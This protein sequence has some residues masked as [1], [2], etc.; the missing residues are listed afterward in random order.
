MK[1]QTIHLQN[2]ILSIFILLACF[3]IGCTPSS[4]NDSNSKKTSN[5]SKPFFQLLDAATTG[6]NFTNEVID[7]QDFNILTYRNYYNG[8]GVAIGDINNDGLSDIFFTANLTSNKLYLNKG[9]FVFEEI[10]EQAG[11]GGNKPWSTGVTMA[12]VNGDGWLDIYVSNSGDLADN[13]KENELFINNKNNTFTESATEYGLDNKGYSTQAAFFDYDADGDL[14]CYLLNNSFKDP[15]KIELYRSMR[16]IPDELGGDKLYRNDAIPP[17]GGKKGGF[18]D[19]SKEAG[20]YSS[21]IGFGLGTCIG[22]INQDMLPDIYV[23]N[24]FWERDYLY[25]NQG[26][27]TFSEELNSRINFCPISSMGGD[28]A[29]LNNDG[30]PEIISTDMLAADN[31]RLKAMTKFDPFHIEDLKYRANY[32]YQVGQNCLQLNDGNGRFQEV[33]MMAKVASTDWSWGAL[34]FDFENDGNKDLFI[35]NGIQRD[36][37]FMDFRDFMEDEGIY[38]KMAKNETVDFPEMISKMPSNPLQN[39]AFSND[40]NLNF[41][42]QAA[43]LGFDQK[44][45]SNGAAYA[46]L[47]NDGDMDL[48]INNIGTPAFVY[49]NESNQLGNNFLKIN[50]KGSEHNQFGIGA[51]VKITTASGIQVLQ[52]F[53][54]RG[55]ESSIEPSLLFGLGKEKTIET[56]EVIWADKKMQTLTNVSINQTLSLDYNNANTFAKTKTS[57]NKTFTNVSKQVIK[58]KSKHNENRYNDFN[59]EPLLLQML[60]TESPRIIKGDVNG[61]GLEDF[62]TLG[63]KDDEDKLFIQKKNGTL[64][65]KFN[66]HFR[67]TKEFESGAGVLFDEDKDGDL[68]LMLGAGGNEYLRGGKYFI[69][70]FYQNDGKGNFTVNNKN[71]PQIIGNFSCIEV[72]DLDKDGNIELFFGARAVPGNYGLPARSYL[73]EKVNGQWNDI[74]TEALA[75]VGMVTDA[76]WVDVDG[77]KDDDLIVVGDWMSVQIFKNENGRLASP[78]SISNSSGWWNRIE[79]ADLDNDG[80]MDFV[81]GNRGTNSKL[82][83]NPNQPLTMFVNDFDN[84]GKSE[85]VINWYPPLDNKAFPFATKKDLTGQLPSLRKKVLKYTDYAAQ[86]YETLFSPEIKATSQS[87]KVDYLESAILWNENGNLKLQALPQE[88]QVSPVFGIAID[89][90]NEDGNLDIWLGGNLY[91]VQPQ[92][93]R[94]DAS[95]GILLEG[96][97]NQNFQAI[98]P[99]ESG[100]YVEGE[101]RDAVVLKTGNQKSLVVARND[102]TVLVFQK[103]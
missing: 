96:R 36:L 37:M 32:H 4:S 24:D 30:Y 98:N 15:A 59:H 64:E 11:V 75:G 101:V 61:D 84:N 10:T 94:H 85:F 65:R 38:V 28:I 74:T 19:V 23:S 86:T 26:D 103:K 33:G 39:Y 6:I 35:S 49:R 2:K 45:F 12:D 90:L 40:G 88:A 47:D 50:F 55:F 68:D 92:I 41:E 54:T 14:D 82:Q 63:A 77:D 18:V 1:K 20:I 31:F 27:G 17:K 79:S 7:Q 62:I 89:D 9:N 60:S 87:Y 76:T 46:D 100:I 5:T 42:D 58:G 93:G 16:D 43:Q 83:A 34:I 29:D 67:A 95:R 69:L 3:M 13:D 99:A 22:D 52:N 71:I 66:I 56:L 81:L 80:D 48:V 51:Q 70:R 72:S 53:N 73:L 44:T 21:A 97:G 25:I 8:G 102:K 91:A 57:K 78:T